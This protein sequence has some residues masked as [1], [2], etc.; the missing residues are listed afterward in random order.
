[1]LQQSQ[2]DKL[3]EEIVSGYQPEKIY[4]FGSYAT[5]KQTKESD[6]DLFII[7]DTSER[8]IER[9][10][11]VRRCIKTYPKNGLDIFVFT[12]FE[13]KQGLNQ[14][15]NIGK[16]AVTTGKLLYERV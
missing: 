7:K 6:I 10:R 13:L 2:I 3:I 15:I 5:G 12:P 1:M 16:E 11:Q 9:N 8:K 4:L 14:V